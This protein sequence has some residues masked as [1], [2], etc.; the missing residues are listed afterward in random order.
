MTNKIGKLNSL[1]LAKETTRGAVATTGGVWL[2]YKSLD[3]KPV[4]SYV[5]REGAFGAITSSVGADIKQ[6]SQE[7]TFAF[8]AYDEQIPHIISALMGG[9]PTT[10]NPDAY[11]HDWLL[12]S[13]IDNNSHQSYTIGL[14]GLDADRSCA[15][16]MLESVS[17]KQSLNS[18]LEITATYKAEIET[19]STIPA[20]AFDSSADPF[21]SVDTIIKIADTTG[22]LLSA[23]ET[24][25]RSVE[26]NFTKNLLVD[27]ALGD[28]N[29]RDIHNQSFEMSG[30]MEIVWDT[31]KTDF[32]GYHIDG[33]SKAMQVRWVNANK[34]IGTADLPDFH[35]VFH[36]ITFQEWGLSFDNDTIMSQ[37]LGFSGHLKLSSGEG[38]E[39]RVT[40]TTTSYT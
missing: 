15:R 28:K 34:T 18:N 38:L 11:Q 26:L 24:M 36:K 3:F 8:D 1:W 40:N 39:A 7:V 33:D 23:S 10:T 19:A 9:L 2:P 25:V 27:F 37:T 4:V 21:N 6:K 5:N 17:F 30:T 32:R 35:F 13:W 20:P 12:A 14:K 22:G 29:P 16:G 31:T